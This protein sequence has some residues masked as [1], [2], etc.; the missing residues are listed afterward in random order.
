MASYLSSVPAKERSE[1]TTSQFRNQRA[2]DEQEARNEEFL[3][4]DKIDSL[5]ELE[6]K[7]DRQCIP[8]GFNIQYQEDRAMFSLVALQDGCPR[9]TAC[10]V[11]EV[12]AHSKNKHYEGV[13][14]KISFIAQDFALSASKL[15]DAQV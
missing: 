10:F 2:V 11:I 14:T 4:A 13:V 12:F 6:Q 9:L 3:A 15:N 8:K 5:Q 1:S 7:L